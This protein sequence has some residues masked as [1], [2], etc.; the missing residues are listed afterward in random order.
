M[1]VPISPSVEC[2]VENL[3]RAD[4]L[5]KGKITC[6]RCCLTQSDPLLIF[7]VCKVLSISRVTHG[8]I[9]HDRCTKEKNCGERSRDYVRIAS[10]RL[11]SWDGLGRQHQNLVHLRQVAMNARRTNKSHKARDRRYMSRTLLTTHFR[12]PTSNYGQLN[13]P[14]QLVPSDQTAGPISH[15]TARGT[16]SDTLRRIMSQRIRSWI[17]VLGRSRA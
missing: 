10:T 3:V 17:C 6:H 9:E 13:P 12:S 11:K 15:L 5:E 7:S 1:D 14:L 16:W 2:V 4:R 8:T